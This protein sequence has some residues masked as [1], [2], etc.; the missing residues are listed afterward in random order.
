MLMP[1]S[2][3]DSVI[4]HEMAHLKYHHHGKSFWK[5]LSELLGEDANEQKVRRDMDM[6]M[7]Y[8]YLDYI[9]K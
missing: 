9:L 7:P 6:G 8:L 5:F 1:E 4:L 3:M 2:Y